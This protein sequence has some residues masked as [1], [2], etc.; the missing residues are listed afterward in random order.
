MAGSLDSKKWA[1]WRQ[2]L[3]RFGRSGSAV[4][5]E[6]AGA[7]QPT[8]TPI[9]VPDVTGGSQ[10][11]AQATLTQ[12]GFQVVVSEAPSD[13]VPAGSVISQAPQAGVIASQG[14]AVS[15]VVSSG[16]TPTPTPT[17]SASP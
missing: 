17:S 1:A 8:A 12:A 6:V 4:D 13:S 15:I 9:P 5:L 2:R 10:A 7:P 14:S 11:N 3:E 16:P